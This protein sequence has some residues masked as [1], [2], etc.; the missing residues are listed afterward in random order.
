[1]DHSGTSIGQP[2]SFFAG[3]ALNLC[4]P[5]PESE[6]KN[7]KRKLKAG[8]DFFLTQP[9]YDPEKA[10]AF[11]DKF[12]ETNGSPLDKPVLVGILPLVSVRHANFLQNEVP[13]IVIP[14]ETIERIHQA[15]EQASA[16]GVKIAIELIQKIKKW[17]QGIYIMP[18]FHRYDLVAEIIETAKAKD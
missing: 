10:K 9:I 18:Q 15:G 11:L 1:M 6:I 7:L 5:D 4:P 17:G 2:T 13:G 8:A 16:E 12:T 14:E 3:S